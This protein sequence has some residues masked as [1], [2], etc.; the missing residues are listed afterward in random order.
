VSQVVKSV[1]NTEITGVIDDSL[2]PQS[3][4]IFVV[5]LEAGPVSF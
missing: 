3:R 1:A 5:V 2:G 4:T